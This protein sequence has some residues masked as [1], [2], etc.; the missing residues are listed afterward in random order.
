MAASIDQPAVKE[1]LLKCSLDRIQ[2]FSAKGQEGLIHLDLFKLRNKIAKK[3]LL[4]NGSICR[5]KLH[6]VK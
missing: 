4:H 2:R 6:S 5:H 1:N 3:E